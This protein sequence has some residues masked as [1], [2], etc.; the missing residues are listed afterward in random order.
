MKPED[1]SSE[2]REALAR[3]EILQQE[4]I[5]EEQEERQHVR[6]TMLTENQRLGLD[7][8]EAAGYK[9]NLSAKTGRFK[10]EG[11]YSQKFVGLDIQKVIRQIQRL[12][13]DKGYEA[14][15]KGVRDEVEALT[16]A[17]KDYYNHLELD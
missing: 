3:N 5:E 9:V 16:E 10:I 14:G 4:K 17:V 1:N 12:S 13:Y 8:Y 7:L 11:S 2:I 6:S 15:E